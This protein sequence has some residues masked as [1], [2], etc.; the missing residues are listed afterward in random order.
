MTLANVKQAHPQT[1]CPKLIGLQIDPLHEF[2]LETLNDHR[3]IVLCLFAGP[4]VYRKPYRVCKIH[5]AVVPEAAGT[6]LFLINYQDPQARFLITQTKRRTQSGG[7]GANNDAVIC[8][9][10][11]IHAV[12]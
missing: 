8:L 1:F 12:V 10:K 9:H 11:M 3:Q 6:E 4:T 7:P 2:R 5:L